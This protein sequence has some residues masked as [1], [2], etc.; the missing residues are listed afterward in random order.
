MHLRVEKADGSHEVYLHTKVIGAVAAA[1]ADADTYDPHHAEELAE[2]VRKFIAQRYG[3]SLVSSDEIYSMVQVVL[4]ET[5]FVQAALALHQHRTRREMARRRIEV[6]RQPA[7]TDQTTWARHGLEDPE[8]PAQALPWNKSI[9]AR[10][11]QKAQG[12]N[13]HLARAVA[14]QVEEKVLR[15]GSRQLRTALLRELVADEL[16]L[17]QQAQ[18]ALDQ[19]AVEAVHQRH[20]D[21]LSLAALQEQRLAVAAG[22]R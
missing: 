20:F 17:M 10:D 22:A 14:G 2:A 21:T 16:Y 19:Q 15:L 1:L 3:N 18:Y 13:L 7:W 6:V 9:I 4:C 11:L 12:L 8:P 5:G